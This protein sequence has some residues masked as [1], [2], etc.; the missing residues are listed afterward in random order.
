MLSNDPKSRLTVQQ[1]KDHPW[2]KESVIG[3]DKIKAEFNQRKKMV[4]AELEKQREA[5]KQ[6]KLKASHHAQGAYTGVKPFRSLETELESSL[7]KELEGKV[8]LEAKR[9]LQNYQSEAGFKAYTE[10]FTVIDT[11][12]LFKLLCSIAFNSLS[13]VEVS[14][15]TYKIKGK[16]VKDDGSCDFVILLRK[17]NE[18]I[19]CIEFQKRS[20]NILTF[21][22]VIEEIKEKLPAVEVDDEKKG[23]KIE[24]QDN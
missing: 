19:T 1:I 16:S 8:D 24:A 15:T 4:D 22:K 9:E 6:E 14:N 23:E 17:V 21:Y 3:V 18:T 7:Q 20:G 10:V 5:K 2:Y 11:D 12:F 13:N